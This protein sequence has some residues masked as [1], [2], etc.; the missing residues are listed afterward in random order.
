LD[1]CSRC[2]ARDCVAHI[3][4]IEPVDDDARALETAAELLSLTVP[5]LKALTDGSEYT[6]TKLLDLIIAKFFDGV[7]TTEIRELLQ[8]Y[9]PISVDVLADLVMT[10]EQMEELI[11]PTLGR[12]RV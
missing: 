4:V 9:G 7:G 1:P 11:A 3:A 12:R 10:N 5:E 8:E 2:A 6:G